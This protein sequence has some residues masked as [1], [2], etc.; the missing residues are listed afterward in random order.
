[1]GRDEDGWICLPVKELLE[2]YVK[3]DCSQ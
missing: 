3:S 2:K 1:L